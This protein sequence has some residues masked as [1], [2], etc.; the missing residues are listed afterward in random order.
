MQIKLLA[1]ATAT[2]SA[3]TLA[4]DGFSLRTNTDGS[5]TRSNEA[6]LILKDTA[7]SAT[8]TVTIK[9]WIYSGVIGA[10]APFGTNTTDASR[11][12]INEATAIGEVE[13]DELQHSELVQGLIHADR[14]YAEITA[15][16]GTATAVDLW[17]ISR[18]G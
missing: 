10:W 16:G 5:V 7:G 9:L 4:T 12:L 17:L 6:L 18:G 2:N 3:P 14:V 11:G 13:A 15:I 1:A 8:M